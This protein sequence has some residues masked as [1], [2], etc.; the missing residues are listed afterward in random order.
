VQRWCS[1]DCRYKGNYLDKDGI[2]KKAIITGANLLMGAGKKQWLMEQIEAHL[3]K[4]CKYCATILDLE[5]MTFD[6]KE[7][8]KSQE[9]RRN[10]IENASLRRRLDAKE[11]LHVICQP[12]NQVKGAMALAD[13]ES[14]LEWAR[15]R[16]GDV[17]HYLRVRLKRA[18]SFKAY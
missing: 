12:C 3:G 14:L 8:Y 17:E 10:K 9:K 2:E 13:F 11:N 1:W 6:H 18:Q 16:G 5:N 7:P 4:A 15:S